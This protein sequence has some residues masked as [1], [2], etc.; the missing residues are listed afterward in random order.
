M[1][2]LSSLVFISGAVTLGVELSAARLLEPVFGNNQ[3]VWAALIGLILLYLALGAWLGG[4]LA[5][6]FPQVQLLERVI[7]IG[8]LGVALIPV[9]SGPVLRWAATGIDN[10]DGGLLAGALLAMLLLFSLP[11]VLLGTVSPWAVRLAVNNVAQ[12]GQIAGRLYAIA[13]AG[14]LFGTFLPVLWLIPA[15][16]T[17]R[18][19]FCLACLPLVVIGAVTLRSRRRW[20]PLAA[21]RSDAVPWRSTD[22]PLPHRPVVALRLRRIWRS[23]PASRRA[24]HP[25]RICTCIDTCVA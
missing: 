7:V 8:A 11:I 2:Y 23:C 12:A 19:F 10:F 24:L 16:G 13:T 9:V 25:S 20:W 22:T 15:Y 1:K 5:D 14:S 18:T 17:R 21:R 4:K 3:I 6:R